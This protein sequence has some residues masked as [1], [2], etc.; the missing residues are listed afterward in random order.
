MKLPENTTIDAAPQ[1]PPDEPTGSA[2]SIR[3]RQLA[4]AGVVVLALLVLI[5]LPGYLA[6]RPGFWG[7]FPSLSSKYKPWTTST[8][9]KV[10][11][12]QCH[13]PPGIVARTGYRARMVGEFYLSVIFRTRVPKF[14]TPTNEACLVCHSDLRSVSPKGDL[15]I[16]HRAHVTVLKM[17]CVQCHNYLV[18]EKNAAG[19]HDPAM[20]GCLRCHN[21]D[22]AKNS[23]TTCHT[24]KATPA[25]HKA[26]DWDIIHAQQAAEPNA[27]CEK[28]HA[29]T[30]NWCAD[31]HA[32]R[33]RSHTAD[34]RTTHGAQVSKHRSCEACHRAEFCIRC[35]GE[36]PM[37]N[38][39]P[40]LK[41]VQ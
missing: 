32:R 18:H 23:C 7:R 13:I 41:P 14:G 22:T 33:P 27:P 10:S 2:R 36:L 19:K 35:H 20:T 26:A 28:C 6:Q 39:N 15:K 40:A 30:K 1:G 4:L 29:W 9:A 25:T 3:R 8:H 21:G 31:C 5:V 38:F 34:W 17:Q 24:A 12:E 37:A 11:C 16:P